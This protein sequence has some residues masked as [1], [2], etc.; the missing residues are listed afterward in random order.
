[1]FLR[2]FFLFELLR[3]FLFNLGVFF[4]VESKSEMNPLFGEA[5]FFLLAESLTFEDE[6]DELVDEELLDLFG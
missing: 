3:F 5:V 6:S 4:E 2:V 1:M